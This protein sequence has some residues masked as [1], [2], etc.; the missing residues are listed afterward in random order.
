MKWWR[1]TALSRFRSE[2]LLLAVL[3]LCAVCSAVL[4]ALVLVFL[5][6]EASPALASL[7]PKPFVADEIWL[8]GAGRFAL[9]PMVAATLLVAGGALLL[10]VPMGVGSAVFCRF[11]APGWI[12]GSYRRVI[13]LLAG[14]PSVVYGLWGL[15]RLV[16]LIGRWHPPGPSLLA[17]V[18][19]L[20][21]MILPTVALVAEASLAQVSASSIRGALALGLSRW[22]MVRRVALPSARSGVAAGILLAAGRALGETMAVM[23]VCGNVVQWPRSIFDP[24]RTLTANIA[25]EMAYAMDVHRA[26]LFVSGLVVTGLVLLLVVL[27]EFAGGEPLHV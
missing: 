20:A 2:N 26:A 3:L 17:A 14:I 11:Y 8:P 18:L 23:M 19:V 22:S 25:L 12:A 5:V 10:A 4:L 7:G 27:A 21:L 24:V 13:Q 1:P 15:D 6:W 9:L 16:P